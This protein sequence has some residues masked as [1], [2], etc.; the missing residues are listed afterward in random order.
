MTPATAYFKGIEIN[1]ASWG[2]VS[3][4]SWEQSIDKD[5]S[6]ETA[7]HISYPATDDD[8]MDSGGCSGCDELESRFLL[9][10]L[11][12]RSNDGLDV[13]FEGCR[14][15][16]DDFFFFWVIRGRSY[17]A[18]KCDILMISERGNWKVNTELGKQRLLL[19][20]KVL[21][22]FSGVKPAL[23]RL[24]GEQRRH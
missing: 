9:K 18:L 21:M 1:H 10:E 23:I 11:R 7:S 22:M 24:L 16:L 13:E 15:D 20:L 19:S 6:R 8:G 12:I 3:L 14:E 17:S 4:Y 5:R 2:P